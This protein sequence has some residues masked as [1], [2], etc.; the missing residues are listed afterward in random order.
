MRTNQRYD[1]TYQSDYYG[2][3]LGYLRTSVADLS[4]PIYAIMHQ[5]DGFGFYH[6]TVS[7]AEHATLLANFW[8]RNTRYNRMTNRYNLRRIYRNII[9][10]A[11]DGRDVMPEEMISEPYHGKY[12][13]LLGNQAIMLGLLAPIKKV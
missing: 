7:G 8:G 9:N 1:K 11:G 10:R 3:D 4:L 12:Q 5:V 2:S 13:I 6:E